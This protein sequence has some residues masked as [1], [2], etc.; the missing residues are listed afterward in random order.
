MLAH[1]C[2]QVSSAYR[3]SVTDIVS[4]DLDSIF[5]MH[6]REQNLIPADNLHRSSISSTRRTS[7]VMERRKEF[8]DQ[9]GLD[10]NHPKGSAETHF[11]D[12]GSSGRS[13]LCRTSQRTA[14]P[15]FSD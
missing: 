1:S 4:P 12:D 6:A 11:A 5:S 10:L 9:T 7:T 3:P 2:I 14:G 8:L 13:C 15:W